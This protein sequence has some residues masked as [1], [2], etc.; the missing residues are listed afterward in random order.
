M[1]IVNENIKVYQSSQKGKLIPL[2]IIGLLIILFFAFN[3]F[4]VVVLFTSVF[5]LAIGIIMVVA[6][7]ELKIKIDPDKELVTVEKINF[8]GNVIEIKTFLL[9]RYHFSITTRETY[10][11]RR[12]RCFAFRDT[13]YKGG[14]LYYNEYFY[15]DEYPVN[16]F[17]K[18]IVK[19]IESDILKIQDKNVVLSDELKLKKEI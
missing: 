17:P 8:L 14:E 11:H 12:I 2:G 18:R 3:G 4:L 15:T 16:A 10:K 1:E 7:I 9:S 6:S 13:D 5:F 19:L